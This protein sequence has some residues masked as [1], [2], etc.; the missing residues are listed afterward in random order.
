MSNKIKRAPVLVAIALM[1]IGMSANSAGELIRTKRKGA[2]NM[3]QMQSLISY[4]KQGLP[5]SKDN[6]CHCIIF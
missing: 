6:S 1:E 4:K 2:L 3:I 5:S